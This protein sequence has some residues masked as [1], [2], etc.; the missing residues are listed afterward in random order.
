MVAATSGTELMNQISNGDIQY[1]Q[2]SVALEVKGEVSQALEELISHGSR[3]R[4]L[5]LHKKRIGWVRSLFYSER[6][7][8]D[9]LIEDETERVILL[10]SHCT[11]LTEDE[12]EDLD[13]YELNS[14]LNRIHRANLAD[15]S[16]FPYLS[17]FSTTQISQ[18]LWYARHDKLFNLSEIKMPDGKAL[19]LLATP[20]HINLWANLCT[21]REQSIRKLEETLNFGTLIKAQVGKSA[22]KYLNELTKTLNGFTT[23]A[24]EPWTD[25][26]DFMRIAVDSP[27]FDDG[28]GHSHQDN[29]VQGLMREMK[30]MMEGDKHEALMNTF[31]DRQFNEAKKKED[32]I[33]KIIQRRREEMERMDDDGSMVVVTEA[34]VKRREKAIR[35]ASPQSQL[36]SQLSTELTAQD[37]KEEAGPDRL[38]KYFTNSQ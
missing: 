26:V 35:A 10:L 18:N 5:T 37:E 14:V 16:L 20:D 30:G 7:V 15:Y 31:Y 36:Q 13:I 28:F 24:L 38:A 8:L 29:S 6:K 4:P 17:A 12:I 19:R 25:T 27:K 3:V 22:D 34:E 11:S 9:R 21:I 32:E 2:S 1:R 23:D 33:Q